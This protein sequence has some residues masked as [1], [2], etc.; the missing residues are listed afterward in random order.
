MKKFKISLLLLLAMT[1]WAQAEG[2]ISLG[3][4]AYKGA[5]EYKGSDGKIYP[6]PFIAYETEDYAINTVRAEYHLPMSNTVWLDGLASLRLQGFDESLSDYT[7][8]LK[9]RESSLDAG[10]ALNYYAAEIGF[11]ALSFVHDISDVHQ[12]HELSVSYSYPL[13]WGVVGLTPS[14]FVSRQSEDL[15]DYYYGVRAAEAT[16]WRAAYKGQAAVNTGGGLEINYEFAKSWLLYS[17]LHLSRFGDTIIS[18]PLVDTK[19]SWSSGLGVI[20]SF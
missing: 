13:Q 1:S 12:G 17:E 15:V 4:A 6:I 2:Q 3:A 9:Q 5:S 14:I 19:I 18:S 16:T 20:Y 8:G 10:I 7:Q 11:I